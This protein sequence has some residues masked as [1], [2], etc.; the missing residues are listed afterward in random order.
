MANRSSTSVLGGEPAV[1][2][3]YPRTGWDREGMVSLPL[4]VLAVGSYLSSRGVRVRI[5]DERVEAEPLRALEDAI[6]ELDPLF[7]GVSAMTGF[8]IGGALAA[9]SRARSLRPGIPIV[10]G[11]VHPSLMAEQTLAH[12]LADV[13]VR[14]EGE[15][16]AFELVEALRGGHAPWSVAGVSARAPDGGLHHAPDRPFLDLDELPFL[17]TELVDFR[18]YVTR[19]VLGD[20]DLR[21]ATSR[22]CPHACSYCYNVPFNGR[23]WRA[24]SPGRVLAELDHLAC[25]FGVRA[26]YVGDDDF[27]ANRRRVRELCEL[28]IERGS[29]YRLKANCLL[30]YL[31]RLDGEELALWRRA[32]FV[33]LYVGVETASPEILD[34]VNKRVE[35]GDVRDANRRLREAGIVPVYSFMAGFPEETPARLQATLDLMRYL[36]REYPAARITQLHLLTVYPGTPLYPKAAALGVKLPATLEAWSTHHWNR[37]DYPWLDES[38]KRFLRDASFFTGFLDGRTLAEYLL[39]GAAVRSL[40]RIYG[41]IVRARIALRFYRFMPEIRLL[42]NLV[43]RRLEAPAT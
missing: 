35:G 5:V 24:Q 25:A 34:S 8:Q 1:V 20:W 2:L 33:E 9:A 41:A 40:V 22:G 4:S 26:F 29:P 39:D 7:V 43:A 38:T 18:R 30:E 17:S 32:G 42:A 37:I 13:V 12:P 31:V 15:A 19:Q 21:I 3:F 23:R 10:W 16:T 14:G 28:L 11:G 36:K 6:G 27:F